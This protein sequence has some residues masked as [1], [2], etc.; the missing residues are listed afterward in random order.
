[1]FNWICIYLVMI[2]FFSLSFS[3]SWGMWTSDPPQE[4]LTEFGY[5]LDKKN[6]NIFEIPLCRQLTRACSLNISISTFCFLQNVGNLGDFL[7]K[8]PFVR[9]TSFFFIKKCWLRCTN[10]C[11]IEVWIP[12]KNYFL[13]IK[14]YFTH[15]L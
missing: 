4:Y 5:M 12:K 9:I 10:G 3:I 15:T 2:R 6:Y 14:T 13:F 1:M 7:T 8:N 11:I